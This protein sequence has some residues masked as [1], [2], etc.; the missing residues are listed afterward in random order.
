MIAKTQY[1]VA[2]H[3]VKSCLIAALVVW[4]FSGVMYS[5]FERGDLFDGL[6]WAPTTMTTTGY[7][8]FFP[9][10]PGVRIIGVA[11]MVL[12]IVIVAL[13]TATLASNLVVVRMQA[14]NLTPHLGDDFDDVALRIMDLK[15]R[16]EHDEANDDDVN[17]WA[18]RVCEA[19]TLKE[20]N[21][22]I[23]GLIE[24]LDEHDRE[25]S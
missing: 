2:H 3:L 23:R 5:M 21:Q 7:G 19:K 1:W 11:T 18:R 16:Y 15:R 12:G 6:W 9:R 13:L 20:R 22:Y 25:V 4:I 17:R 10:T 8:D 24:A 14:A